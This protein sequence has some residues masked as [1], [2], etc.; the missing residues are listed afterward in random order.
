MAVMS[1]M[2]LR[3][4]KDDRSLPAP[5]AAAAA[6]G[7]LV[8]AGDS[9]DCEASPW[10]IWWTR[11]GVEVSSLDCN[12]CLIAIGVFVS[13]FQRYGQLVQVF[14]CKADLIGILGCCERCDNWRD[15]AGPAQQAFVEVVTA[16]SRFEPV[17]VCAS[18]K[19]WKNARKQLPSDVRV[20]EMSMNDAW[21]RDTGPTFLVRDIPFAA[22]GK[23][24]EVVG[25]HWK[26]NSW[27]GLS[28]GA[29]N[30]WR[31]DEL[32][33]AKVDFDSCLSALIAISHGFQIL[34]IERVPRFS[35]SMILEGGSVHVDGE[36]TCLTTE[37]C[38]LNPNRNPNMSKQQIE[39]QLKCYLG[40]E[41]VIWVPL[42]LYGKPGVV[43]LS[44]TDDVNDPQY[45]RS[46]KA[47]DIFVNTTDA[48]GRAFDVGCDDA[49]SRKAG[50]RLAASYVN[51]YIANGGIVAPSF[52]DEKYDE[53]AFDVLRKTF[54]S[55]EVLMI[56]NGREIVLGGGNIHCIT[57][58]QPA[59]SSFQSLDITRAHL[60]KLY[61]KKSA[62]IP[63]K[64]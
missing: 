57:Q 8:Q 40:V 43:L 22:V 47:L 5:P 51:F 49:I 31:L 9:V 26:F 46:Q 37:E 11:A 48:R 3:Y 25:V 61:R 34:E 2:V 54:P 59:G 10:P 23:A 14:D 20:L 64:V 29:Y 15:T 19:E 21:F 24:R 63:G 33:G 28:G 13:S 60:E 7:V 56:R 55:H 36:G 53:A 45:E 18:Q 44:W 41:K 12:P 30:D 16:I 6:D 62:D 42:G 27:G 4:V 17:T 39:E 1:Y 32:V 50:T 58:Q 38:L 35:H 52:G